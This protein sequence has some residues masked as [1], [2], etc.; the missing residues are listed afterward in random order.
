MKKL[1]IDKKNIEDLIVDL[2]KFLADI[3]FKNIQTTYK[4]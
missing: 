1:D 3:D 4:E 2:R